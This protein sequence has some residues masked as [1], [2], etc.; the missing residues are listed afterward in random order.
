[1]DL[2][3]MHDKISS[4]D[5]EYVRSPENFNL[6]PRQYAF[7]TRNTYV[8]KDT[9]YNR[10]LQY[11]RGV[12]D[13]ERSYDALLEEI[14]REIETLQES[15]LVRISELSAALHDIMSHTKQAKLGS[16][17]EIGF[18]TPRLLRHYG[19]QF[20]TTVGFDIA[21]FN[22]RV[23]RDMGY[24]CR[25]ADLNDETSPL[26]RDAFDV[27]VCYHVLEHSFDPVRAM[28]HI[29]A[30]LKPGGVLHIETPVEPGVPRLRYG[31]L[32]ALEAGDLAAMTQIAGLKPVLGSKRTHAG[33]PDVERI[34]A[35]RAS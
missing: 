13:S 18:R 25:V 19:S 24:D 30:S 27:L 5:W 15:D 2:R 32:I 6:V 22:V 29:A 35:I 4:M 17:C 3:E 31:H 16:F 26:P 8:P 12:V 23:A 9:H 1:M 7:G 10:L 11:S 28:G 20:Q 34:T 21:E 33:G 14:R